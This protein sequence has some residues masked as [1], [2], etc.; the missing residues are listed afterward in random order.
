MGVFGGVGSTDRKVLGH[1]DCESDQ[2]VST[3]VR[4]TTIF[5]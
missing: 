1:D 3:A 4:E 5:I 2:V